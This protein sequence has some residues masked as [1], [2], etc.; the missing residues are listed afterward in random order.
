MT[1]LRRACDGKDLE[2]CYQLGKLINDREGDWPRA[3]RFLKRACKNGLGLS[4]SC[5]YISMS[6]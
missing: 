1:A 3:V 5:A 4:K 2:A 6:R